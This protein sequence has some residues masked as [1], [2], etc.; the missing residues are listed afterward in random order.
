MKPSV[1]HGEESKSEMT[2]FSFAAFA[3]WNSARNIPT[4]NVSLNC[5][6]T[7]PCPLLTALRDGVPAAADKIR[8]T[9]SLR[10]STV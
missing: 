3:V 1:K 9:R 10:S 2:N 5:A 4:M 6:A 7:Q 8:V